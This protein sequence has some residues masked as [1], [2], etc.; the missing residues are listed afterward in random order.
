M[1]KIFT[2]EAA[3]FAYQRHLERKGIKVTILEVY[4]WQEQCTHYIVG[5]DAPSIIKL[6][7]HANLKR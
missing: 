3:A 5:Q 2:S 7:E 6:H 4:N 1:K